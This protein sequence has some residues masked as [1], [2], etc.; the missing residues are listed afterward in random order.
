MY[1][2]FFAFSLLGDAIKS[3]S[4]WGTRAIPWATMLSNMLVYVHFWAVASARDSPCTSFCSCFPYLVM[5]LRVLH[6]EVH[7]LSLG[8]LSSLN[9]HV[10]V[11]FWAVASAPDSP[12][13][14][15]CSCFPLNLVMQLRVL[16]KPRLFSDVMFNYQ[17]SYNSS[18]FVLPEK[19]LF[20]MCRNMF[21]CNHQKTIVPK[22]VVIVPNV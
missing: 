20:Q 3:S 4:Q 5:Q 2:V 17:I 1:L 8:Q 9:M 15:F 12:C 14:S 21:A 22:S 11:Q 19:V 16:H 10:Y 6:N 7:G 18:S 13:T